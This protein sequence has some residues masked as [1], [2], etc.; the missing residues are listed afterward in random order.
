LT[1]KL[2]WREREREGGREGGRERE[3]EREKIAGG[4]FSHLI[5]ARWSKGG[6]KGEG[7]G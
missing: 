5:R 3:R 2:R 6:G 1:I 7:V 4:E